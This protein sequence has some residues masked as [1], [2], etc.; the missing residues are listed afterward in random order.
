M[1]LNSKRLIMNI[2]RHCKNTN[3]HVLTYHYNDVTRSAMASQITSIKT[4][5]STVYSSSDQRKHQSSR[6]LDFVMGIHRWPGN[7]P[8]NGPVTR[9]MFPFDDVIMI[10]RLGIRASQ[11]QL[12]LRIEFYEKFILQEWD[13]RNHDVIRRHSEVPYYATALG[14]NKD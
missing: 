1:G 12:F 2:Y 6:S 7:S 13:A 11:F 5:Y 3:S 9:K 14:Y 8:H 4:V 10:K